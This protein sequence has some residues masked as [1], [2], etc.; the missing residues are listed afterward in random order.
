MIDGKKVLAIIPARGGSKRL[1]RKNVLPLNGKPLIAWTIEAAIKSEFIDKVIVSTDDK[2]V[3]EISETFG[4]TIPF[5]RPSTLSSDTSTSVDV[6]NHALEFLHENNDVY[7]IVILLQPTSPL[8]TTKHINEAMQLFRKKKASGVISVCPTEHSPLWT[9]VLNENFDMSNFISNKFKNIRSQDLPTYYR[10]NGA[11]Y[12]ADITTFKKESTFMLSKNL[13]AYVM[14][15]N[16]S[17]DIDEKVDFY[18]A[19]YL[20]LNSDK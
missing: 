13:F 1:P 9:N 16:E 7:D 3:S 19:K 5:V 15:P 2:E 10:L 14:Q 18:A 8:R 20:M 12:I 11:I 6:V 17:T 4:A